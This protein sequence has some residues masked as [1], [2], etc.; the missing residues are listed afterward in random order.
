MKAEKI[1]IQIA[2]YRDNQL[3]PTIKDCIKN[4]YKPENLVFAIAWQH[5]NE[6]SWDTLDEFKNDPRFKIIDINYKDSL[7]VCWARNRISEH[8]D[9]EA[10][11]LQIDSHH[12][13]IINW[14]LELITM[15]KDL[16]KKGYGKPLL[17]AYLPSFNPVNDPQERVMKPWKLNF[18][19]FIPEGVVF[20]S[21]GNI[22]DFES[23][24]GPI[25]SRFF[26]GHF[27][28]T[29][30]GFCREVEYD[31][32]YYFHGE[33]ISMTVRAFTWGYDL[34]SPHKVIAWHEYTRKYRKRHWDDSAGWLEMN[35]KSHQRLR[36]LFGIDGTINDI[37][38]G[39]Y[40]FGTVRS[41]NDYETYAGISFNR[42]VQQYTL[43]NKLPPNP[44]IE[45]PSEY[46]KSFIYVF[47]D[48]INIYK[49]HLPYNDYKFWAVIFEDKEGNSLFRQDVSPDDLAKLKVESDGFFKIWRTFYY[50]KKPYKFIV[51][52]FSEK[53]GWC[54]KIEDV[55]YKHMIA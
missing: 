43:D 27:C 23:L 41:L 37:D 3:V 32:H 44:I 31:P 5:S 15:M 55:I 34:F 6:D 36:K 48:C 8:Y 25:R 7:G 29:L 18:D 22:D 33:E 21:P 4:S 28:F 2:S 45:D 38:F 19:R 10:Y 39:K 30:G 35:D 1:F 53:H 9:N 46:Q 12:R 24:E 17:T 52:P 20:F 54:A 50:T 49:S 11:T 14:D 51:W 42:S 26:S 16:Q 47:K 13:F 40:G